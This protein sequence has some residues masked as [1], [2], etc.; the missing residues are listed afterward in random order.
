M[1]ILRRFINLGPLPVIIIALVL[2]GSLR[3]GGIGLANATETADAPESASAPVQEPAEPDL[4]MAALLKMVQARNAQLDAKEAELAAKASDLA[5]AQ[6]LIEMNLI[7]L[8]EAEARLAETVSK[9]DGASE[10]DL[11]RLT[12]VYEAMKPKVAA[13]LFEQMTPEF[14]AGFLGR[15]A[16]Q[17]AAGIMSGLSTDAGYAISVVL[18]GRN[19]KAPKQ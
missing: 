6:E 11:D 3:L 14:A 17:A 12:A 7:K 8:A 13:P 15:M 4:D 16:P 2:S 19:A 10:A 5:A 1:K 9:V 18:A